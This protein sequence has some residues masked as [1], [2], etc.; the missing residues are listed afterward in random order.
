M[1]SN[2]DWNFGICKTLENLFLTSTRSNDYYFLKDE[3]LISNDAVY[4]TELSIK[5]F[6]NKEKVVFRK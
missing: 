6:F 3:T 5:D 1:P 2:T 4:K